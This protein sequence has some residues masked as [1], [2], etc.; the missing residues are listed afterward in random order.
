MCVCLFDSREKS[1]YNGNNVSDSTVS[2]LTNFNALQTVKYCFLIEIYKKKQKNWFGRIPRRRDREKKVARQREKSVRCSRQSGH[3][4][5]TILLYFP[6]IRLIH[7]VCSCIGNTSS[8]DLKFKRIHR[9]Y[10]QIHCLLLSFFFSIF[11]F[12]SLFVSLINGS[13]FVCLYLSLSIERRAW[14]AFIV[15]APQTHVISRF[16]TVL[17]VCHTV[18]P[19]SVCWVNFVVFV[20]HSLHFIHNCLCRRTESS[21]VTLTNKNNTTQ[22]NNLHRHL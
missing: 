22:H 2:V 14:F 4:S 9:M 11:F 5:P 10:S 15:E 20:R 16:A 18:F 7:T 13:I 21:K 17:C 8:L 6:R 1:P 19:F 3:Y 12:V